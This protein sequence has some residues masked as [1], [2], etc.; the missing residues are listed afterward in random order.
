M[1]ETPPVLVTGAAGYIGS[2]LTKRLAESGNQVIGLD[3]SQNAQAAESSVLA[4]ITRPGDW[5]RAFAGVRTVY[6]LAGRAH[7][8]SEIRQDE[9]EYFRVNTDGTR[10][11]LE[12]ARDAGVQRVVLFSSVKAM[13]ECVDGGRVGVPPRRAMDESDDGEPE[14]PYGRSKLAAEGL[15]LEGAFVPEPVVLRL[16]AVYGPSSKG[17]LQQMLLAVARRRFPPLPDVP[18]RRSMVHVED[19]VAAAILA[20]S[21]P[22]AVNGTFIVSEGRGYSTREILDVMRRAL[23]RKPTRASVPLGIYRALGVVGDQIGRIRGK[24][25]V[26]DSNTLRSLLDSAWFSSMKIEQVLGFRPKWD[27]ERALPAMVDALSTAAH[28]IL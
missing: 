12:A 13:Q 9:R 23:G 2:R 3:Y 16:C 15:L 7:A 26:F 25:F 11:V 10:H 1:P 28:A 17:N 18:N 14:T 27:L 6:H 8:I 21:H 5:K 19:V 22:A 20:A 4:D 24:R